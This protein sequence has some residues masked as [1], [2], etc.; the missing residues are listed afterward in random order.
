[1]NSL[2]FLKL[3]GRSQP[4]KRKSWPG[5]RRARAQKVPLCSSG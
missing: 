5:K 3:I 1:L 4:G 2:Q